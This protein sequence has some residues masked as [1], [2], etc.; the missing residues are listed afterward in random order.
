MKREEKKSRKDL[1]V[2]YNVFKGYSVKKKENKAEPEH[3]VVP[4]EMID[5]KKT[6]R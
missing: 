1:E 5:E 4:W 6:S 2:D 3:F